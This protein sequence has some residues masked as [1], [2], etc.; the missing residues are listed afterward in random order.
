M[1][2]LDPKIKSATTYLLDLKLCQVRVMA[3][4]QCPWILLIPR[5][6]DIREIHQLSEED[7]LQLIREIS[8]FSAQI[9]SLFRPDKM[10]VG[11]L[12]NKVPQLHI[13]IIGRYQSDRGWPGAIWGQAD[14]SPQ[15]SQKI[16]HKLSELKRDVVI[17]KDLDS[18]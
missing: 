12:G 18:N 2:I 1:F 8:Q 10:N 3:D 11:A 17:D 5:R 4:S 15:K 6:P 9:D 16:C 7:Q 14:P 13:H